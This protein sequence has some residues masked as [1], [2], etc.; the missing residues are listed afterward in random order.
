MNDA[1]CATL[2]KRGSVTKETEGAA[3]GKGALDQL[4][5]LIHQQNKTARA[6]ETQEERLSDE[7]LRQI[8]LGQ[9]DIRSAL[10][11]ASDYDALCAH[12]TEANV[13]DR[14]M[15]SLVLQVRGGDLFQ[16]LDS[17]DVP[18]SEDVLTLACADLSPHTAF[19]LVSGLPLRKTS[20][21]TLA[22]NGL[23]IRGLT[24]REAILTARKASDS[25]SDGDT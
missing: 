23:S 13:L 18:S 11:P 19:V 16:D 3:P 7:T 15:V 25:L 6:R 4:E 1:K 17:A 20:K 10:F 8:L 24:M 21:E 9:D 5:R 12:A 2:A 14:G 22:D